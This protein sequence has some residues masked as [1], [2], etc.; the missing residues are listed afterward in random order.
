MSIKEFQE[1]KEIKVQ[2]FKQLYV[3]KITEIGKIIKKNL[4]LMVT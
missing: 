1:I 4:T 2:I 3:N